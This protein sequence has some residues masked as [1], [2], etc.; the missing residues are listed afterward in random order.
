MWKT[1][2]EKNKCFPVPMENKFMP[3]SELINEKLTL[4]LFFILFSLELGVCEFSSRVSFSRALFCHSTHQAQPMGA[5]L[6]RAW[7]EPERV[8]LTCEVRLL[9]AHSST[10]KVTLWGNHDH[11]LTQAR[12]LRLKNCWLNSFY[13]LYLGLCSWVNNVWIF[14]SILQ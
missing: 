11:L 8:C 5:P 9:N 13:L 12:M 4:L 3:I 7:V 6:L 10:F 2:S 1:H 14:Q